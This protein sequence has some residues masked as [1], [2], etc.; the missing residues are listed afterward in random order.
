MCPNMAA[1][2]A[3]KCLSAN[4]LS[5]PKTMSVSRKLNRF[6]P[7]FRSQRFRINGPDGTTPPK[8]KGSRIGP[9]PDVVAVRLLP[10]DRWTSDVI[11]AADDRQELLDR[12]V[13]RRRRLHLVLRWRLAGTHGLVDFQP[14]SR[15]MNGIPLGSPAIGV[16]WIEKRTGLGGSGRC[17]V[18]R[19]SPTVR[20]QPVR[21]CL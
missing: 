17:S 18:V 21:R 19:H 10:I 4:S 12:A 14:T 20:A 7:D 3:A 8:E 1:D 5:P 6:Q 2:H 16:A 11:I 13:W 9:V 15:S